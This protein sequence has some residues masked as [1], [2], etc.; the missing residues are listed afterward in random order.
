MKAPIAANEIERLESLH[1]YEILDSDPEQ[2]FDDITLLASQICGTPIALISFVDENRQWFKSKTG[3]LQKETPRE[4]AFCAHGILQPDVFEVEDAFADERFAANPLVTGDP[5]IRFYAGAPLVTDEGYALGMLCVNDR[6]PRK[7]TPAEKAGLQALS[8]QVVAQMELRRH[9]TELKAAQESLRTSEEKFR[10]VAENI[11]DAFW[12]TSPDLEQIYYVSPAYERIWGRPV[13]RAYTHPR[14]W[15]E[16]ILPEDRE[17]ALTMLGKL[18]DEPSVSVEFRI[19]RPNG[20]VRWILSR[21][22]QVRDGE[23]KVIRIAGAATDI[24]EQKRAEVELKQAKETAEAS[25]YAKSDFLANMSHEIRTPMNGVIGMTNLLLDSELSDDQRHYAES[26]SSSGEALLSII[27]DILDFSKI[28]AGK[29]SFETL[30]FDLSETVEGCAELLAQRAQGK[31]LELAC[32]VESNVPVNVRGDPGR[33]RQVLTNLVSNAIKFT[34]RGEVV[35]KVSLESQTEADLLLRFEVRD[36]G[37]G[38]STKAQERLFQPFSQADDSTTRKYGGTGL[39]LAISKQLVGLMHG[40]IGIKS[41]RGEGSIF[42]FTA[43]LAR[44]PEGAQSSSITRPD[45]FNL[46]VLIVDDN[47]TNRQILLC[48]TRAWKMRSHAV[49]SA[50]EALDELKRAAAAGDPYQFALLDFHMPG[51]DGLALAKSIR[52]ERR[53]A[54]TRLVLLSS[55]GRRLHAEELKAAGIDDCLVKPIKQLLLLDCLTRP[56]RGATAE[57]AAKARKVSP[58]GP[59]PVDGNQKLRILVAEDNMVNQ[60]VAL[61]LLRKLGWRA[62]TVTNGSEAL[63]ALARVPYDVIL[64]DCQMPVFD[65]YETTRRIRKLEREDIKPFNRGRPIQI[66][67]MTANAMQGDMEKCLAAGMNDYLSKPVRTDALKA[68]LERCCLV[69]NR[70]TAGTAKANQGE[71]FNLPNESSLAEPIVDTDQ[72]RDIT[73]D[74]PA[75]IRQLIDIYLTQTAPM[76]NE[77]DAAIQGKAADDVARLA[78]KLI[79]SSVSCGVEAFTQPLRELERLGNERDLSG[80]DVLFE[81]LR[82]KFPRVKNAFA[83]FLATI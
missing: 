29:L 49:A 53:L 37:I 22:F 80:A 28:E 32:L 7:L 36:T 25:T 77:L 16:A 65:G 9:I 72:L 58:A 20:D 10:Q 13:G 39:G 5:K 67:A 76:L 61:G 6:V 42:W 62:D 21:G 60:E 2:G 12:I 63:E 48:Q 68:A 46:N 27:N 14:E 54:G 11:A 47:E 23:G 8:R 41:A 83:E 81:D 18:A 26:I 64:M 38:I 71:S 43:R 78:H 55:M 35:V 50:I 24:T 69:D 56:I 40:Q 70:F 52:A 57:P 31:G 4:I 34:D 17:Q 51:M 33:L 73:D 19:A 44:Q 66:I 1:R 15:A 82:S 79:G 3:I 75:R 30:D 74:E 45:L 59:L